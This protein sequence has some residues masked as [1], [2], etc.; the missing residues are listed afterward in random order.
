MKN[1]TITKRQLMTIIQEEIAKEL[2]GQVLTEEQ[3]NEGIKDWFK[4]NRF[5]AALLGL[6]MAIL[7]PVYKVSNDAQEKQRAENIMN[8][9]ENILDSNSKTETQKEFRKYLNNNAAFRWGKGGQRMMVDKNEDVAVMPLSFTIAMMAYADKE[10]GRPPRFG[11]PEQ[12]VSLTGEPTVSPEQATRNM[13][14]FF[15]DFNFA[16]VDAFEATGGVIESLPTDVNAEGRYYSVVMVDPMFLESGGNIE[17]YVLPENMKTIK[18]YY[19][20]VYYSQFMSFE[21]VQLISK[22][23]SSDDRESMEHVQD[24]FLKANPELVKLERE[25]SAL[26]QD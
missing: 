5:P 23:I 18:E 12:L 6:G 14:K 1:I 2:S 22:T 24:I 26:T 4:R 19:N 16:Y 13:D 25:A 10:M 8:A 21:D 9:F 17:N 7:G 15:E 3:L 20:W 11:V